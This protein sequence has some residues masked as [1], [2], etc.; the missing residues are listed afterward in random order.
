M[1]LSTFRRSEGDG[2]AQTDPASRRHGGYHG[3]ARGRTRRDLREPSIV[4]AADRLILFRPGGPPAH[5]RPRPARP[6]VRGEVLA[7]RMG[8]EKVLR[9]QAR[10]AA[11]RA[12]FPMLA[13]RVSA[14]LR[15]V[16]K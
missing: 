15:S 13:P 6:A 10:L 11:R 14:V 3:A 1:F 12:G 16:E 5:L 2:R 7:P 9:P 8:V 4:S